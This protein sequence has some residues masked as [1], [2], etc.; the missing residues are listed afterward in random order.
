MPKSQEYLT[1]DGDSNSTPVF[2]D[3]T[4]SL[5]HGRRSGSRRNRWSFGRH[6]TRLLSTIY[7]ILGK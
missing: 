1:E 2:P 7:G 4:A 3:I 5:K 6:S